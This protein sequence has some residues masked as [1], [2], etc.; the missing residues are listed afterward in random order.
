[1]LP[2]YDVKQ[3]YSFQ[4]SCLIL[5]VLG[6]FINMWLVPL[7]ACPVNGQN[8]RPPSRAVQMTTRLPTDEQLGFE[9]AVAAIGKQMSRQ[10]MPLLENKETVK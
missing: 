4:V 1:M 9:A 3:E 7:L 8:G 5:Y 6:K 10:M 2:F